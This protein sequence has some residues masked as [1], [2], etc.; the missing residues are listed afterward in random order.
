[1][2]LNREELLKLEHLPTEYKNEKYFH[3]IT[4]NET[5][6]LKKAVERAE[7]NV[8]KQAAEKYMT[9]YDLAKA[10]IQVN[11]RLLEN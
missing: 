2:L 11:Q 5:I 10:L 3:S 1:M 9:T 4:D 6:T 8:L 7:E